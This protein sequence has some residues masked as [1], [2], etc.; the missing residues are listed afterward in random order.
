M[1]E[2][3]MKLKTC[4][5]SVHLGHSGHH[6]LCPTDNSSHHKQN[7]WSRDSTQCSVDF[8]DPHE[9]YHYY[10]NQRNHNAYMPERYGHC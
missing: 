10:A 9:W 5:I 8:D 6:L 7:N 2:K 1:R 4:G 3:E